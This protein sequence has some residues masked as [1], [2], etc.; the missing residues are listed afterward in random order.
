VLQYA[1]LLQAYFKNKKRINYAMKKL[2]YLLLTALALIFISWTSN[3]QNYLSVQGNKL[4]DSYGKVV[5]LTGVNW[6]GFE[7]SNLVVH[8]IWSRDT[9][10]MLK[11]IKDQ[12]FNVIRLPWCNKILDPAATVF[13]DSY[14]TDP[15]TGVSPM[16]EYESTFTKPI[17][18]L[19]D[20]VEWCQEN[21]MKLIL[22]N[23]SRQPD[24]YMNERLWYT[25]I[26]P[27]SK[28]IED[29]VFL[30]N[31]YKNYDAVVG[32]DLNNEPHGNY[33]QGS[34]WGNSNPATDWN[35]AAER[36]GNAILKVNPNVLIFVEGIELY[37]NDVY[38]WG[39]NLKGVA[40]FPVQLDHPDKL[41][42]SPHEYGPTVFNQPWFSA[43]DFP[44]NMP[45]IWEEHFNFIHTQEITPLLVGEF[46][47][48]DS[49]GV[50]EIW[51]DTFM[52]Y[53]GTKGY[54]WTFWC[55]NPNSGDT[56]GLLDDQ[57]TNIVEWKMDK[58]RPYLAPEI[59][60]GNSSQPVNQPP[61]A[62]FDASPLTGTEPLT[63]TF[64][65]GN[66]Y[67]PDEDQIVFSWNFGDG[68]SASGESEEHTFP[69]AGTYTVILTVTD[70]SGLSD[71]ESV[72]IQVVSSNPG[73]NNPPVA[74][75][76]VSATSGTEPLVVNFDASQSSDP[77]NDPLTYTWD[78]G[79][80]QTASGVTS[81]HTYSSGSY[82][83]SVTVSDGEYADVATIDIVVEPS[84]STICDSPVTISV[85]FLQDGAGEYCW[86][87]SD[88]IAHIN[89]WN[90]DLVEI[91]GT[92]YTNEWSD[93]LPSR[94]NGYY[95]IRY[96]A[97]YSWSHMEI[98]GTK[99]TDEIFTAERT[100][101]VFPNPFTN[102]AILHI[103]EPDEID[104]IEVLDQSGRTVFRINGREVQASQE[105]GTGLY[106][107]VYFV[108]I[109]SKHDIQ[110]IPVHKN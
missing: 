59:P 82:S 57:W 102:S 55:W 63:V 33:G 87:T 68:T 66:S 34:T 16:N 88:D 23:H 86:V 38:W 107:G 40:D 79:D 35:K 69:T 14:G 72:T 110:V 93:S 91:N 106:S 60:N 20:I 22:D 71:M 67:D 94:Q 39:G 32:M 41:V 73:S 1:L 84:G 13:I 80:G 12:G 62:S 24:G 77:E 81:S 95:Y 52:A 75:L 31:R 37:D 83:A 101:E 97:S 28:W 19:D 108:R 70:E 15:Y 109:C 45:D 11:Q 65:A 36:C 18:L 21:N 49:D 26:T 98:S 56:G 30:A 8:G 3:A 29:W 58:L 7:T 104:V 6:F 92:D 96:S 5:R 44:D 42:Y 54:S 48:R 85:P 50:D 74:A 78:F 27:E 103:T 43:S 61:V 100:A 90:M 76:E 51:F 25:D 9:K 47:I 46:G 89:S 53:M 64:D 4:V 105:I 10:S 17:E 99:S 2:R